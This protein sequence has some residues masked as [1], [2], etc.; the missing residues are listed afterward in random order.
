MK[1]TPSMFVAGLLS[2]AACG[3]N[4]KLPEGVTVSAV[5]A[6]CQQPGAD[7]TSMVFLLRDASGKPARLEVTPSRNL[8]DGSHLICD[9]D[10]R[11]LGQGTP[12]MFPLNDKEVAAK[13]RAR[14]DALMGGALPSKDQA[15][16]H[17]KD[18]L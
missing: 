15:I 10:G 3:S 13:E 2:A 14:I 7:G 18:V 11:L 9:I 1:I 4:V 8:A 12:P 17:C 16:V 6:A 5:R